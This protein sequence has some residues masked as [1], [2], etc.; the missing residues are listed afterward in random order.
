MKV[1]MGDELNRKNSNVYNNI[2]NKTLIFIIPYMKSLF[3]N[4][5]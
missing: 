4:K 2:K 3:R 5:N 1:K